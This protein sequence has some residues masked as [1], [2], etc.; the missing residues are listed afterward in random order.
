M[1]AWSWVRVGI[2][3]QHNCF[4]WEF[5]KLELNTIDDSWSIIDDSSGSDCYDIGLNNGEKLDHHTLRHADTQTLFQQIW[6][7]S[8][9]MTQWKKKSK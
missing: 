8:K 2:V 6:T 1:W 9:N 5:T 3:G 7:K 4:F